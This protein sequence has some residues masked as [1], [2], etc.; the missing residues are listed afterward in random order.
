MRPASTAALTAIVPLPV[1]VSEMEEVVPALLTPVPLIV[2]PPPALVRVITPQP[3][4]AVE[5][6][7][8]TLLNVAVPPP[9]WLKVIR[10]PLGSVFPADVRD[11]TITA[12]D[13]VLLRSILPSVESAAIETAAKFRAVVLPMPVDAAMVIEGVVIKPEPLMVP[14]LR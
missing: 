14:A 10:E 13:N 11:V 2:I 6:D 7:V 9:D 8:E 5:P 3:A 12:D 1:V 4:P